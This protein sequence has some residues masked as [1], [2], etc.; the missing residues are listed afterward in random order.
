MS[1][2][3]SVP[4]ECFNVYY[5]TDISNAEFGWRNWLLN[6]ARVVAAAHPIAAPALAVSRDVMRGYDVSKRY[7][8]RALNAGTSLPRRLAG[9]TA[10]QRRGI[11]LAATGGLPIGSA[12]GDMAYSMP[13]AV[14]RSG[15]RG[16][17]NVTRKNV[18]S[19]PETI[20]GTHTLN[21]VTHLMNTPRQAKTAL[22]RLGTTRLGR[23]GLGKRVVG[24]GLMRV[25]WT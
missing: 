16:A 11:G 3:C 21:Q 12:L 1:R 17:V 19:V 23:S 14:R 4:K 22:Q 20:M 2:S 25:F 7:Q 9:I 5:A 8:R 15:V 13:K 10:A 6:N 18:M 24:L